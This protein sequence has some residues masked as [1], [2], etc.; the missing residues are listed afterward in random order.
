MQVYRIM[1]KV[2]DKTAAPIMNGGT[3]AIAGF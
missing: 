1:N 2:I 3:T